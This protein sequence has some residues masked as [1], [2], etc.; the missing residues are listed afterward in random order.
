MIP[1][2]VFLSESKE[3]EYNIFFLMR[4]VS[5]HQQ[6]KNTRVLKI[7]NKNKAIKSFFK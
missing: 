7:E 1:L 3:A 4:D 2:K 6:T 5:G